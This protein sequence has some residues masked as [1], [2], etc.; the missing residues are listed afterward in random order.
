MLC[1]IYSL[2][3][4]AYATATPPCVDITAYKYVPCFV[5]R[6]VRLNT[7]QMYV[8]FQSLWPGFVQAVP[9]RHFY[10]QTPFNLYFSRAPFQANCVA[11]APSGH[12]HA[13]LL[14]PNDRHL[15]N[16]TSELLIGTVNWIMNG[17]CLLPYDWLTARVTRVMTS[18]SRR[19]VMCVSTLLVLT[20]DV[21]MRRSEDTIC[22][23][24]VKWREH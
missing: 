6:F 5:L 18:Q 10:L 19:Y 20:S 2:Y 13:S 21:A 12:H 8:E 7:R 15:L 14:I 24:I 23:C 22:A 3:D 4:M 16:L 1:C 11:S 17:R 9:K